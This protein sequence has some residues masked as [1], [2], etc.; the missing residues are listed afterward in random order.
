MLKKFTLSL[1]FI[2]H[3]LLCHPDIEKEYPELI[4]FF[5]SKDFKELS[6][7]FTIEVINN[8]KKLIGATRIEVSSD[9]IKHIIV[10]SDAVIN[11][12]RLSAEELKFILCHELGHVNDP[13]LW[14]TGILPGLALAAAAGVTVGHG[15]YGLV[16]RSPYILLRT[17]KMAGLL[18]AGLAAVQYL[19]RQGEYFADEFG[20][21]VTG[22]LDAAIAALQERKLL[23]NSDSD[24]EN[25][26]NLFRA[27]LR[28]LFADHPT[29]ENRIENLKKMKEKNA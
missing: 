19:S 21:K 25:A 27:F 16:N 9:G 15:A 5:A 17:C 22:N 7:N 13:R 23:E 28:T 12:Q 1:F 10:F 11:R 4:P 29:E 18:V 26:I 2:T 6:K 3:A 8:E 14:A 24:N 20:L